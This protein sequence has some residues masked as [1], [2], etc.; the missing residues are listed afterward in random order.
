MLP[1]LRER[2]ARLEKLAAKVGLGVGDVPGNWQA[3]DMLQHNCRKTGGCGWRSII[4]HG[5]TEF[6]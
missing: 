3:V 6:L 1:L 5:D 4:A 2:L